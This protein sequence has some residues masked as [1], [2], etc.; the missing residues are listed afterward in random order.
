MDLEID[1]QPLLPVLL[2]SR[3]KEEVIQ[4]LAAVLAA[5]HG[6]GEAQA[7][8]LREAALRREAS[9]STGM[10]KG[11]AVPHGLLSGMDRLRLAAGIVPDGVEWGTLD[12]SPVRIVVLFA[13]PEDG[14]K[15]YLRALGELMGKLSD[16]ETRRA[17]VQHVD[18]GLST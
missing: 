13:V 11:V 12:G 15:D 6:L 10:E 1:G 2:R 18:E 7:E 3:V 9:L 8:A 14:L 5:R 16:P 4:E 17:L